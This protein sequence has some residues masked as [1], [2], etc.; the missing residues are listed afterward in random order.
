ELKY[1][2]NA[3][4]FGRSGQL[5]AITTGE[6]SGA[7]TQRTTDG[8]NWKQDGT[9][10]EWKGFI[11]TNA[12]NGS[13]VYRDHHGDASERKLDGALIPRPDLAVNIDS[14]TDEIRKTIDYWYNSNALKDIRPQL[15][16][17]TAEEIQMI[18][19]VYAERQGRDLS[20]DLWDRFDHGGDSHRWT[21]IEGLL[22]KKATSKDGINA[23]ESAI[24]LAVDATEMNRWW[25]N[26]DRSKAA[27]AE[28]TRMV[29]GTATEAERKNM[30][31]AYQ[32]IY[33]KQLDDLYKEGGDGNSIRTWDAYTQTLI[34][35]S[36]KEGKDLRTPQ[37]EAEILKASLDGG[38]REFMEASGAITTEKGRKEFLAEDGSTLI[39]SAFTTTNEGAPATTDEWAVRQAT[40]FAETGALRPN[41]AIEKANGIFS[42]DDNVIRETLEK[43]SPELRTQFADGKALVEK[44]ISRESLSTD[45]EREAFDF[46]TKMQKTFEALHYFGKERKAEKYDDETMR[47]G[48]TD[49]SAKIAP[50]GNNWTNSSQLNANAVE[51]MDESTFSSLMAGAR[52]NSN[53]EFLSDFHKQM[54]VAMEKNLGAAYL[55]DARMLLDKKISEGLAITT[56]A[57]NS[58][59]VELRNKIP[60][61]ANIPESKFS[62]LSEGYKLEQ[63]IRSNAIAETALKADQI[64]LLNE[65]RNDHLLKPFMDGREVARHLDDIANGAR[66]ERLFRGLEAAASGKAPST[67]EQKDIDFYKQNASEIEG[68]SRN[69]IQ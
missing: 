22:N 47:R 64:R 44:R 53:S 41:T 25:W 54:A 28:S 8:F 69:L 37:E 68:L 20:K 15:Q 24:K 62:Q 1:E 66:A 13:I 31:L 39:R 34:N 51:S 26:R 14:A 27:I 9:G 43:L 6:G 7:V 11:S 19:A 2:M 17:R 4:M 45:K 59:L 48:G 49:I 21:E 60:Q 61:L 23:E 32:D 33:K 52:L 58:N 5:S 50:I 29:L 55:K 16:G 65:Y 12:A 35:T 38:L 18:K 57:D 56:A 46:Y 3:D 67:E 36:L 42:N 30:H 10:K 40:D 63:Q